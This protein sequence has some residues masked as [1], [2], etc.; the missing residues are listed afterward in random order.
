MVI[1]NNY[2]NDAFIFSSNR[3]VLFVR[4]FQQIGGDLGFVQISEEVIVK[5]LEHIHASATIIDDMLDNEYLRK[6][7]PSY[8]VRHGH[9]VAAFAALNLMIKGIEIVC[10][11][12]HDIKGVL[13][14]IRVMIEAE[15]ADVGLQKRSPT[16]SP[17]DWYRSVVSNKIAGELRLILLLCSQGSNNSNSTLHE[18]E[19]LTSQLG[20]FIQY[21]DDWYDVLIKDPF[22]QNSEEDGYVL[23]YSLPLAIYLTNVNEN[24]ETFVGVRVDRISAR[25]VMEKIT[26]PSN[27]LRS[28][29]F[30]ETAYQNLVKSL[31]ISPIPGWTKLVEV[32]TIV[33]TEAYWEKKYYELA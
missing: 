18:L 7:I 28:E 17:L 29:E 3:R 11:S 24:L 10:N 21:C 22:E 20:Q 19:R 26:A 31:Q 33:K 5:T 16:V 12:I 30:I 15:E 32:A 9:S 27:K 6:E 4:L 2:L 23:T 14:I 8:Y 1:E 25:A 13:E